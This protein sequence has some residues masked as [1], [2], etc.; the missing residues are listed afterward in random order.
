M[1]C[2]DKKCS[3]GGCSDPAKKGGKRCQKHEE[4]MKKAMKVV[5]ILLA[6]LLC[7]AD[8]PVSA[9]VYPGPGTGSAG[10]VTTAALKDATYC[11]SATGSDAYACSLTTAPA[12]L[13]AMTGVQVSFLADVANTG[14]AT[15]AFNGFAA[16]AISKPGAAAGTALGTA[17]IRAGTIVTVVYDGTQFECLSCSGDTPFLSRTQTWAGINSFTGST[18]ARAM[19]QYGIVTAVT[20]TKTTAISEGNETITNTGDADGSTITLMNDPTVGGYWN[21]AVTVAQTQTIVASAGETLMHGASTCGTSL[22]SN[23]IGSTILIRAVV[24]GSGGVFMTF[25]ATG[26]WVCS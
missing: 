26:T 4:A 24:G 1:C 18:L 16:T 21:F 19:Y 6:L 10:G 3:V 17:D 2:N 14:A 23:T 25:G 12:N 13:A 15:I 20:T 22:T 11:E 5:G 7:R 9:Q 8:A